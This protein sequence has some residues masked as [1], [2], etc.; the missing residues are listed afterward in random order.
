MRTLRTML[1]MPI[2]AAAALASADTQPTDRDAAI[3]RLKALIEA[4][5]QTI[6][7]GVVVSTGATYFDRTGA[8]AA[9]RFL[10]T[11]K[12]G[13]EEILIPT[14]NLHVGR[15]AETSTATV[16]EGF[17]RESFAGEGAKLDRVSLDLYKPTSGKG[18]QRDGHR[19]AGVPDAR[20]N[21]GFREIESPLGYTSAGAGPI[22][23]QSTLVTGGFFSIFED[24]A[25]KDTLSLYDI[26]TTAEGSRES[27]AFRT[28]TPSANG[29]HQEVSLT[30]DNALD[31][32]LVAMRFAVLD[33]ATSKLQTESTF[34]CEYAAQA[35]SEA[36]NLR[37]VLKR[38]QTNSKVAPGP[39][40]EPIF[41]R[42]SEY[43]F[44]GTTI[45]RREEPVPAWYTEV[46]EANPHLK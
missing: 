13:P 15:L 32:A 38:F 29:I 16:Y 8:G 10:N 12:R 36:P 4:Q 30:F 3:E 33:A 40:K 5:K 7:A 2:L 45:T 23:I 44:D 37:Y 20:V 11:G 26:T 14:E 27:F 9:S 19:K 42:G 25:R 1:L 34:S 41:Q 31:G 21:H 18:L 35:S 28:T 24:P 6:P 43:T 22:A 39:G 17:Y 46:V